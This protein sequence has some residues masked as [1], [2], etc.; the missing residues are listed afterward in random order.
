MHVTP[1]N[2]QVEESYTPRT[3]TTSTQHTQS[4]HLGIH[5]EDMANNPSDVG[6]TKGTPSKNNTRRRY[7]PTAMMKPSRASDTLTSPN[8]ALSG[9][10][11]T[12]S[13]KRDHSPEGDAFRQLSLEPATGSRH[14]TPDKKPRIQDDPMNL[15]AQPDFT[16]A[17]AN[18]SL[19]LTKNPRRRQGGN[20]V[21]AFSVDEEKEESALAVDKPSFKALE[22][23][24]KEISTR[25]DQNI[26][27]SLDPDQSIA[28]TQGENVE[29]ERY[30]KSIREAGSSLERRQPMQTI[31]FV[32]NSGEGKSAT[33]SRLLRVDDIAATNDNGKSGTHVVTEFAMSETTQT[34]RFQAV[35]QLHTSEKV[36]SQVEEHFANFYNN[37]HRSEF[38][39][40]EELDSDAEHDLSMKSET[41]LGFFCDLLRGTPTFT[42]DDDVKNYLAQ[43]KSA[44]D[45]KSVRALAF[46]INDFRASLLREDGT[47]IINV[48]SVRELHDQKRRFAGPDVQ[49]GRSPWRLVEKITVHLT[50]RVLEHGIRLADVPGLSD[51]DLT[52]VQSTKDYIEAC[53]HIV[54]VHNSERILDHSDLHKHMDYCIRNGKAKNMIV[55]ATKI[56]HFNFDKDLRDR[57]YCNE[58]FVRIETL[59]QDKANLELEVAALERMLEA[60]EEEDD[61]DRLCRQLNTDI[62]KQKHQLAEATTTVRNA[63]INIRTETTEGLMR[64]KIEKMCLE[65]TGER[66]QGTVFSVSNTVHKIHC[67]GFKK[68]S[69]PDLDR[70]STGIQKLQEHLMLEQAKL[71][72]SKLREACNEDLLSAII[73]L[74]LHC[75]KSA[76]ERKQNMLP[77]IEKPKQLFERLIKQIADDIKAETHDIIAR[78]HRNRNSDWTHSAETEVFKK[79]QSSN[80]KRFTYLCKKRGVHKLENRGDTL[81][82]NQEIISI[83][84]LDLA[85]AFTKIEDCIN[86]KKQGLADALDG[87]MSDVMSSLKGTSVKVS[88]AYKLRMLTAVKVIKM[89]EVWRNSWT[90][91]ITILL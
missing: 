58:D 69:P 18:A 77:V 83:M 4:V 3:D 35:V 45:E 49:H 32:G 31:V 57:G 85:Q 82:M 25:L 66:I 33:I 40:G 76:T 68:S 9:T 5:P 2:E 47:I 86:E 22:I 17:A 38:S 78:L 75:S 39:N 88:A 73:S 42:T 27:K 64:A 87:A 59:R 79:W 46:A 54:V 6:A 26:S 70:R 44:N 1:P 67:D 8:A 21:P 63:E 62:R 52:R 7:A 16:G 41:A 10:T 72:H 84:R 15:Q 11:V 53:S 55:L 14:S 48:D 80:F 13:L 28:T 56:D 23:L 71:K 81:D 29:V 36:E 12:G 60:A 51:S 61:D 34:T 65:S 50:A 30:R 91:S 19:T 24:L 89:L 43:A 74:E 20:S 90:L 37:A